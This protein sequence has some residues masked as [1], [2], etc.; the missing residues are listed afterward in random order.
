MRCIDG[1]W[2]TR[3]ACRSFD[4][5]ISRKAVIMKPGGFLFAD[6]LMMLFQ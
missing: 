6:Y 3:K 4:M 1:I 2:E 5:K